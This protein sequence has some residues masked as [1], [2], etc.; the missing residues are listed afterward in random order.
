MCAS[1]GLTAGV[2]WHS[3]NEFPSVMAMSIGILLQ[4]CFCSCDSDR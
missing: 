1:E 2:D 4:C 3:G